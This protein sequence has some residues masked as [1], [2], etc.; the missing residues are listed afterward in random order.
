MSAEYTALMHNQTWDLVPPDSTPNLIGCKWIF[1]VKLHPDG[2]IERDKARLVAQGFKQQY[3]IDFT[4]TFSDIWLLYNSSKLTLKAFSDSDWTGCP[5]TRKSTTGFS[6]FVA[7]NPVLHS[8]TKHIAIDYHFVRE[9]VL[10]GDLIVSH[11]LT[12]VQLVDVFTKSLTAIKFLQA[13]SNLYL[14]L[15]A[16]N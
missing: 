9:K 6:T 11:V 16:K 4:Q 14:L 15:P 12:Q 7:H 10:L 2:T 3:G 5:N 8:R 13:I 1:R